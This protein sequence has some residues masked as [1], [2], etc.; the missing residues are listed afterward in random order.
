MNIL[1][2]SVT[3]KDIWSEYANLWQRPFNG[4][5]REAIIN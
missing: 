5:L 3:E 2:I 1:K 4:I